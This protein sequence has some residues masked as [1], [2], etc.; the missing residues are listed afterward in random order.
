MNQAACLNRIVRK[1]DEKGLAPDILKELCDDIGFVSGLYGIGPKSVVLLAAILERSLGGGISDADLAMYLGCT[2]I[3]FIRYHEN[4]REME[5]AGIIMARNNKGNRTYK[6]SKETM[7]AAEKNCGF[8]PVKMTGLSTDELF[9]RF[10]KHFQAFRHDSVDTQELL[11]ELDDLVRQNKQ[12]E[13]CRKCLS[14]ALFKDCSDTERRIFYYLCHRFVSHGERAVSLEVVTDFTDIMED[15]R[16]LLRRISCESMPMQKI[17]LVCF[18]IDNGFA[19]TDSLAL[20]DK[21]SA[22]FFT[23]IE[24]P[25]E[26]TIRHRDLI[27]AADIPAKTLFFNPAES[28][29][30]ERLNGLLAEENFRAVQDRLAERGMRKG[31]NILFYGAPGTGKTASVHELAR[32]TGRDILHVDMSQLRSKWVGDSE[33]SVKDVFKVYRSLCRQSVKAPI[34]LFNEAD[35]VFSTRFENVQDSVDQMNNTIQNIILEEMENLDGILVATTN[36]Q[37][38][39]DPAFERRFIYKVQFDM[40]GQE[41]R[42]RIWESAIPGLSGEDAAVLAGKYA[43]S[44]GNIEN[45]ARKSTVDYILSGSAPTLSSLEKSCEAEQ[46]NCKSSHTRI[47]F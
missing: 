9:S 29:Q 25:E 12:L 32:T 10:R 2:N 36:L 40:P 38:N 11:E 22:E 14:S 37:A 27:S 39:L 16:M 15:D 34:L 8:T 6:V 42:A 18:G 5:K 30:I 41:S 46:L 24:I 33:K 13:F 7:K 28:A 19:D 17:G 23:E 45:V 31:F 26:D 43:F 35:A 20:S 3:E 1:V 44:G 47:G 21:V 4:L